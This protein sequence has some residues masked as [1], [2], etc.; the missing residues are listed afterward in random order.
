M[1]SIKKTLAV[2]G[3]TLVS[4][5]A[6][7]QAN[8][9]CAGM[10]PICTDAGLN[11]TANA[12]GGNVLQTEPGKQLQLSGLFTKSRLVLFRNFKCRRY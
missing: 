7:G 6:F 8:A 11:F 12:G 5:I 4:G 1:L 2:L 9:T 10:E 3:I